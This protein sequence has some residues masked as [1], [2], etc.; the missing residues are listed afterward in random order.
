[1]HS[2]WLDPFGHGLYTHVSLF[3]CTFFLQFF[4]SMLT[5][6]LKHNSYFLLLKY[7]KKSNNSSGYEED[8]SC[9]L[10]LFEV[11]FFARPS[12]ESAG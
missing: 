7:G 3:I 2:G 8:Y 6:F 11:K 12:V 4:S 5:V 9:D 10:P 1:M